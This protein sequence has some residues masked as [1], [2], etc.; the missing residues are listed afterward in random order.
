MK[1]ILLQDVKGQG[2]KGEL[3]EVNDGYA[4]NFLIK[5][6][7][8]VEATA[9]RINELNQKQQATAYH[10]EEELKAMRA[11]AKEIDGKT[12]TL[13][14][15]V[16]QSGKV[17]GSVTAADI[18]GCLKEAGYDI[19]KKKIVIDGPIKLVGTYTVALKLAEGVA[20]KINVEV[21]GEE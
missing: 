16:G 10:K 20:A 12:F 8:A 11:L 14:I 18:S 4:R 19:D 3:K 5:K 15:K 7:L 13:K 2:K 9:T 6:G 21:K 17:F 1:V